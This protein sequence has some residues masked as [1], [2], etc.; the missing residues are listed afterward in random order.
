[1][2]DSKMYRNKMRKRKETSGSEH[3]AKKIRK[4][5]RKFNIV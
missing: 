3:D 4:A 5:H 2:I 1:M